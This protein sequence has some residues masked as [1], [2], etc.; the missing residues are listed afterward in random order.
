MA[1][2]PMA[3]PGGVGDGQVFHT[4]RVR[5]LLGEKQPF[6]ILAGCFERPL[7]TKQIKIQTVGPD[8]DIAGFHLADQTGCAFEQGH[9]IGRLRMWF[10]I[11]L[12]TVGKYLNPIGLAREPSQRVE[13][14]RPPS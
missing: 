14:M 4:I 11:G 6:G 1:G 12:I 7:V 10:Y 9:R 13:G 3:G 2:S 8:H 5:D